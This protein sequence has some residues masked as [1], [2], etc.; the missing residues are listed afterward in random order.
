[1]PFE[2][3]VTDELDIKTIDKERGIILRDMT[4]FIPNAML[5]YVLEWGDQEI[6]F[7]GRREKEVV[8]NDQGT[9]F[10][11]TWISAISTCR[12]ISK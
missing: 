4:P 8:S 3:D 2:N 10:N 9:K 1:M 6:H 11:Y 5:R 12:M 7:S